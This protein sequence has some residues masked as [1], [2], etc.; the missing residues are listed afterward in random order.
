MSYDTMQDF[1]DEWKDADK[2]YNLIFRWDIKLA[3]KDN[4]NNSERTEPDTYY[5]EV[6]YM[7]QRKGKYVPVMIK[8]VNEEGAIEFEKLL[9]DY[10]EHLKNLWAPV[11]GM[12]VDNFKGD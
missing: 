6:F 3:G 11:S 8:S 4:E 7:L 1:L 5:A 2:D 9:K 10:W 12:D